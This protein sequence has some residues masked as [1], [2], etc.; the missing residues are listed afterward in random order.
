[1]STRTI[2][3]VGDGPLVVDVDFGR[4]EG[5]CVY[6]NDT[7]IVI[8]KN[9]AL[10]LLMRVEELRDKLAGFVHEVQRQTLIGTDLGWKDGAA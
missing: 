6:V 10:D 5:L 1:M 8:D 4:P 3:S 9:C 7:T 2:V